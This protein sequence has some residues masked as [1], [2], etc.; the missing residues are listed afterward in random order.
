VILMLAF[1]YA[2]LAVGLSAAAIALV[3][4]VDWLFDGKP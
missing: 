1:E 3:R 2:C 4:F